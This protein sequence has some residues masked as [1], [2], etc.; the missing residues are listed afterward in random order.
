MLHHVTYHLSREAL[1]GS[2][3]KLF[4]AALGFQEVEVPD[5]ELEAVERGWEVRWFQAARQDVTIHLIT[6]E[7]DGRAEDEYCLGHMCV[8]V[9]RA[10]FEN[11][12]RTSWCTRDSGKHDRIWC[13]FKNLRVEV[14]P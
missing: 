1:L 10:R 7:F 14:R 12:K 9:G 11:L 5:W 8:Q 4:M 2:P 6:G 3:V 13:E